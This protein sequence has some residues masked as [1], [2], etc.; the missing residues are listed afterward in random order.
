MGDAL[1]SPWVDI[2]DV[3]Y[4]KP[5]AEPD[6]QFQRALEAASWLL[7]AATGYRWPGICTDMIWPGASGPLTQTLQNPTGEG[8]R[9]LP[10]PETYD[11]W[12]SGPCSCGSDDPLGT[13]C[14]MHANVR[15]P[16]GPVIDVTAVTID[17]T[18]FTAYTIVDDRWVVRTDG[19][20]WPCCNNLV[21]TP[22]PGVFTIAYRYGSHPGPAGAL[23]VEVLACELVASWP[24]N[25]CEDCK[26]PRRLTQATY[27]GASFAVLDPFN[28]L[29]Q[30]RFGLFEVDSFVMTANGGRP[31]GQPA[32]KVLSAAEIFGSDHRVR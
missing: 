23:A 16:G 14:Q 24:P 8:Y 10:M 2:A 19:Q 22:G 18:P 6:G 29:D 5:T 11:W 15:L 4:C 26:L 7:Y 27:E 1:C 21:D 32:A 20:V 3:R 28:F 17:G 12:G 30:G 31:A 13:P 25:N 9:P